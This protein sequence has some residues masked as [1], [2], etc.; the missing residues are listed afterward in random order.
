MSH[1]L[2]KLEEQ[3]KGWVERRL[4]GAGLELLSLC[5]HTT[6]QQ[7][8]PV[9]GTTVTQSHSAP[10]GLG[11]RREEASQQQRCARR[12]GQ[13]KSWA[14]T[15]FREGSPLKLHCVNQPLDHQIGELMLHQ[16]AFSKG[17][18]RLLEHRSQALCSELRDTLSNQ[19][20]SLAIQSPC[21]CRDPAK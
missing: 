10:E 9:P 15:A 8:R 3:S 16:P 19:T 11:C 17:A 20:Q 2:H 14:W 4:W 12:L 18:C 7:Q 6:Q 13:R 5:S 1:I 21:V